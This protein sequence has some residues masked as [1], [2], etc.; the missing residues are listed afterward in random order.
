MKKQSLLKKIISSIMVAIIVLGQ[1]S[2]YKFISIAE[3]VKVE[4]DQV[5]LSL[6]KTNENGF[7]YAF[8]MNTHG[9]NGEHIWNIVASED[10]QGTNSKYTSNFYCIKAEYSD[11]WD[12][13]G[14]PETLVKYNKNYE[15]PLE[16]RVGW[17]ISDEVLAGEYKNE[18]LWLIDNLYIPGEATEEDFNEYLNSAGIFYD[19]YAK[20]YY[21]TVT[22]GSND[23]TD[24]HSAALRNYKQTVTDEDI[25]AVQQAAIWYYTNYGETFNQ[26]GI[27]PWLQY[28]TDELLAD[29][30]VEN[31]YPYFIL[32]DKGRAIHATILYNYLIDKAAEVAEEVGNSEYELKNNEAKLWISL[33]DNGNIKNEQPVIEVHKLPE[34]P[35]KVF[36]LSLRKAIVAIN[37]NRE[38][39]NSN[40]DVATRELNEDGSIKNIDKESLV[41]DT[42]ATYKHRKDP[43]IVQRDD[44][45]TYSITIYN[46]GEEAG[47][48]T[49]I[50]DQLPGTWGSGLR[51]ESNQTTVESS[52]QNI[53]NVQY[54]TST[55]TIILAM[56]EESPKNVLSPY[57]TETG[58]LESETVILQCK[59]MG[60]P[61]TEY[62]K[63]L[64]NIAYIA[65]EY[66]AVTQEIVTLETKQDRDSKTWEYPQENQLITNDLGYIG[67]NQ[68]KADLSDNNAYYKG[69]QDDDDFEKVIILPQSFDLSLRKYITK[70]DGVEVDRAPEIDRTNLENG[71]ETTAEYKHRKDAVTVKD[72]SLVEYNISLYNEGSINGVATVVKDQ[73][74]A[75][76]K[77]NKQF[78]TVEG[79]N[80]Y[81]TSTKGNVYKV[82]YDEESNVVTFE[83]DETKTAEVKMLIAHEAGKELDKDEITLQCTVN[84][85][86]DDAQN[87]YLTNI[88][89]IY[90]AKQEDGTVVTN[91]T[92]GPEADRD[93]EP[94]T[95]PNK[96]AEELTTTGE[97]GY[98]GNEENPLDL[99]QDD[100]HFKG[101]QDD[102]DFEKLVILPETFDLSLRK[103]ITEVD[104]VEVDRAPEI[105]RTN[106]ENGTE[107]TA[108]YKHRKDA[109][110]VE[111]GSRVVYNISIYNEGNIDGLATIIRDQL[112]KGLKLN[113]LMFN[114]NGEKYF[115]TS[116]KGNVY[117]VTYI[118]QT[119]LVEF[120][121]D[122][123]KTSSLKYLVSQEIGEELDK[124]IIEL[125]C[126]VDYIADE[127]ENAYFTNI[128]YIYQAEQKDGTIITNQTSGPDSDR[129][130][131]PHTYPNKTAEE[132]TTIGEIGYKGNEEN[133]SDLAQENVHFKGL[134]DDDD[135][136]KLVMEP[137]IFDLKL[138]KFVTAVNNEQTENRVLKVDTS[139]LNTTDKET[140]ADYILE[141]NPVEVKAGD[142]VTYTIRVYNEGNYDGYA[143]E[144]SEDIPEGL[145]FIVVTDGAIFTWDGTEQKDITDEIK[146]SDMYNKIIE[147]NSNWG[148]T[149][150]STIITTRGLS[151]DIIKA[152]GQENIEYADV[153]NKIDYKE[154]QVI[155]RV[156]QNIDSNV[157]IRNEAA[158]SEDKAVENNNQ[159]VEISDRD[160][161]PDEWE[162]ENSEEY[163]DEEEKWPIYKEDDEDY[164]NIVT[165]SF[166]LSLRKQVVKVNDALYTNRFSKLDVNG[167]Y[168]NT[169]YNYYNV[170][171]NK[172]KVK[173]GDIIGIEGSTG[174]V[175]GRHLHFEVRNSNGT[176][177]DAS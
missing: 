23:Y 60:K 70:V 22:E 99:A 19:E 55:N 90:E 130:S 87:I 106:L 146:E 59:V 176:T 37:G 85:K 165:K 170:Y 125:E 100:V 77:L 171:N 174:S 143:R 98:K 158:I 2:S 68:N 115:V 163:Y 50:V 159:E 45:V 21:Y 88:A 49:K 155:F 56:S 86:A 97:I 63:I 38:V 51:L 95:Y 129:D 145:E 94:H 101:L 29:D 73:L 139:K 71:T 153:E 28:T 107:T 127:K 168:E 1:F 82:N 111:Y 84:V 141:K 117:E 175:T 3:T 172:P 6:S 69:L 128:A 121:L 89:Y 177:L 79:E 66:N 113:K 81:V 76:L 30:T 13:N 164:D 24:L 72:G 41:S 4:D 33:D 43:V 154:I 27:A 31:Q 35:E 161:N 138:I 92:S 39:I 64:T 119:N 147:I 61:D 96:T 167:D 32:L 134:Q 11:T 18:I 10:E 8:G 140:T 108:E 62:S 133:V 34:E 116:T 144:I 169:I 173:A 120:N 25:V 53:Y 80:Y 122:K 78:F 65:E 17:E 149:Q 47:Y 114:K 142:F 123:A 105:D 44:M 12:V 9:G 75:G 67:N 14:T 166:D 15:L 132:L 58:I 109:V 46:E 102:D 126:K 150:G 112:P 131:E 162:K 48:A 54:E 93:S 83:I 104:G 57:N 20:A 118:E 7:G 157:L 5:Y 160:S 52:K 36:D 124:D 156:K 151:E 135:F 16:Q 40:G 74:P 110:T 148:Y 103:Y 152:F 137:K 136:E 26:K 42:T 91:Q